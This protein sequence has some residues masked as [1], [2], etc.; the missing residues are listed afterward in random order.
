MP[1]GRPGAKTKRTVASSGQ[2]VVGSGWENGAVGVCV[3]VCVCVCVMLFFDFILVGNPLKRLD[4]K[5][6]EFSF[7]F[8]LV[9]S[10]GTIGFFHFW[11]F[12]LKGWQTLVPMWGK[13]FF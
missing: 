11:R 2:G 3:C 1:H 10:T 13:L 7:L 6:G 8:V 9:V 5:K 12:P 4:E